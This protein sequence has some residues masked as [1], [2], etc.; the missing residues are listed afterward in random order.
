MR[1][2]II[3]KSGGGDKFLCYQDE[4]DLRNSLMAAYWGWWDM[5]NYIKQMLLA[6]FSSTNLP[7]S[8]S[9]L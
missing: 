7:S 3:E 9:L 6:D 1:S 5:S 2:Q 8:P 4:V